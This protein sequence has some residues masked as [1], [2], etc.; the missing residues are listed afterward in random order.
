MATKEKLCK[1]NVGSRT[2]PRPCGQPIADGMLAA[3]ADHRTAM[4]PTDTPGIF[5]RG[6]RYVVVTR[7]RGRQVKSFHE[8]WSDAREAKSD[9]TGTARPAPQ[10]KAPFEDYAREWID[11]CQGR[12]ARGFDPDTR[13]SYRRALEIYAVS[14]FGRT[15]LRDIE[16]RDVEKLVSKMQRQGLSASSI[17]RYLAAVRAMF[18]DAVERG[19]VTVNPALRMRIN[20]KAKRSDTPDEPARE[21]TLTLTELH[22]IIGAIPERQ[23]LLFEVLAGTGCRISEALG[24]DWAD[25]ETDGDH[26]T[27]RIER[28]W[29][30]GTLKP[31]AKTE[32]GERTIDLDT[33]LATKLWAR[34]ADA[35]GLMFATRTG[36]RLSD[37]NLR[38]VL[39][40]ACKRVGL[41]GVGFHA[42]RHTHGSMLIDQGWTIPEVS[43]RLGHA[44]PSITAKVYSHKLRDRRRA[45]PSFSGAVGN[46]WATQHPETA[47]NPDSAASTKISS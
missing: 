17:A 14:H 2:D 31:N 47:A 16:R 45:V 24:F 6:G 3:C 19:D 33:G 44:D 37:R 40:A 21:K 38:R 15:P 13:E 36:R 18:S 10:T 39:E 29:Y 32:A 30:R 26:T 1:A 22:A 23:R 9:R 20:A 25:L 28:Q 43:E 4:I 11:H 35:A 5:Y 34:G 46:A 27:L 7:H 12:T 41:V 8:K 42:F